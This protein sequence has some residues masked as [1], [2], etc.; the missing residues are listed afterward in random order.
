MIF[1]YPD[2]EDVCSV[3]GFVLQRQLSKRKDNQYLELLELTYIDSAS[4]T[5]NC[6]VLFQGQRTL[7]MSSFAQQIVRPERKM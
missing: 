1:Q 3:F 5:D 6:R 4:L 7:G 2:S